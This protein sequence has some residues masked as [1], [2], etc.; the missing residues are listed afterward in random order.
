MIIDVKSKADISLQR[1]DALRT[2]GFSVKVRVQDDEHYPK[3]KIY[4]LDTF[5]SIKRIVEGLLKDCPL[6]N[7]ANP[8]SEK[9]IFAYV[10]TKLAFLIEYDDIA[11]KVIHSNNSLRN[12]AEDYLYQSAGM[13]GALIGRFALCSG[14]SETLRNLLAERGIESKYI[15][16]TVRLNNKKGNHAWNQVKLDGE[17]FNCDITH[18]LK[19]I[20]EGLPAQNFLRSNKTFME[21]GKYPKMESVKNERATR[22]ISIE[23]QAEL[24]GMWRDFVISENTKKTPEK[25]SGFLKALVEKIF[26]KQAEEKEK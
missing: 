23:E 21:Y 4:E 22:D 11:S 16:G 14:F 5:C 10:Y 25:K 17:W 24:L 18:D 20:R 19:N 9:E 13:D 15:T 3:G 26:Q 2:Q 8:N 1:L 12:Y 7:P 6:P